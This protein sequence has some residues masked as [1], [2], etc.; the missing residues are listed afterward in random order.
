MNES[1]VIKAP[2]TPDQVEALNR[3][4]KIA[5]FHPFTCGSGNRTDEKHL[6]GEGVLVATPDGWKCP[7]CDYTQDWAHAVMAQPHDERPLMEILNPF[8]EVFKE[9]QNG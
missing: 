4:Q 5:H 6:D 7:Y 2:F 8:F 3:Y 1:S 9:A